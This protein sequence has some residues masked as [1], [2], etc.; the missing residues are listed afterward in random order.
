MES[1]FSSFPIGNPKQ[2]QHNYPSTFPKPQKSIFGSRNTFNGPTIQGPDIWNQ[3]QQRNLPEGPQINIFP[4]ILKGPDV[5]SQLQ[6]SNFPEPA[7]Q[8]HFFDQDRLSDFS[9][10]PKKF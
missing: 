10:F 2:Q 7:M 1:D 9:F 6:Q 5:W 3:L 8:E 4:P